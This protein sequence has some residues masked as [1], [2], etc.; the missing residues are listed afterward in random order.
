MVNRILIRTKVVQLLYSYLLTRTEFKIDTDPD[1][2]SS[3]KKFAHTAYVDLLMLLLELTGHSSENVNKVSRYAID[4]KLEASMLGNALSKDMNIPDLMFKGNHNIDKLS[5][6]IQQLHDRIA[7]SNIFTEYKRK[8]K[9]DLGTE[10]T[11][12]TVI[13]ESIIANDPK[14]TE[15]FRSIPGYTAIGMKM[16]VAKV[17]A[18]IKSYEDARSGYFNAL[19]NLETALDKAY[20]LYLAMFVLI[21]ELTK[22]QERRI[23]AAK[24]KFLATAQDLNPNMKFVDNSFARALADS[25]DL[26]EL[27]KDRA[28]NWNTDITLLGSL[29]DSI[30]A[31]AI[32]KSYMEEPV[33]DW[34]KDCDFWRKVMKD[35]VLTSDELNEALEDLSVYWNDD[36]PI[37]GTFVLKTIRRAG[38]HPDEPVSF[39]PKFKDDEDASFGA[40]LF[41]KSVA[42]R[43]K[44][45]SYIDR[46]INASNWDT[47]R[48][49]FMDIVIMIVAIAEIIGYPNIPLPVTFNEYIDIANSYSSPKSGQFI[50]GILY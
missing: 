28:I 45:R 5:P 37:M 4:P 27:T 17:V 43:E 40:E 47:D 39:L 30:T 1:L 33:T 25:E 10:V 7:S 6:A 21:V 50:N 2:S 34:E 49:A 24:T 19:R 41:E 18:T 13:F 8:R 44:Y 29:L 42:N 46:F 16:A 12:W 20:E 15:A 26:A 31:S 14:L 23:E 35:I 36:L 9:I 22:E 11:L 32:Y 38:S 48:L 3:D